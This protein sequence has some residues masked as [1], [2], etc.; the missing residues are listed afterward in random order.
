[1]TIAINANTALISFINPSEMDGFKQATNIA[2]NL[3]R[4]VDKK[5]ILSFSHEL[6]SYQEKL[7]IESCEKLFVMRNNLVIESPLEELFVLFSYVESYLA[8]DKTKFTEQHKYFKNIV[9]ALK[10]LRN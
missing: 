9:K 8:L 10:E 7:N 6:Y 2:L 4:Q 1:M 5:Q 3:F